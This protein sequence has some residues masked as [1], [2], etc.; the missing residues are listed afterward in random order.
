MHDRTF[1]KYHIFYNELIGQADFVPIRT[2]KIDID[3]RK[4][5]I[6]TTT[7]TDTDEPTSPQYISNSGLIIRATT[8]HIK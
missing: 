3:E 1:K 5:T 8:P 7:S 6:H 4:F 2:R